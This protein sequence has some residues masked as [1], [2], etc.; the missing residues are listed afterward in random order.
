MH[1]LVHLCDDIRLAAREDELYVSAD[2]RSVTTNTGVTITL[3]KG[4]QFVQVDRYFVTQ[5]DI[6]IDDHRGPKWLV[7]TDAQAKRLKP[8]FNNYQRA[9]DAITEILTAPKE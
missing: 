2:G 1:A 3:P 9:L 6:I 7:V 5:A 4:Q 8:A